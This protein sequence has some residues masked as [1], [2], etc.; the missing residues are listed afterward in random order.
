MTFSRKLEMVCF[1]I[2][3]AVAMA[4]S[5]SS[6]Q[7]AIAGTVFDSTGAVV[8]KANVTIHNSGNNTEVR[9]VTDSSGCF[10]APLLEPGTYIVTV[11]S[12]GFIDSRTNSVIGNTARIDVDRHRLCSQ[13][14]VCWSRSKYKLERMRRR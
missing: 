7:G 8:G 9:L 10:K 13:K 11:S 6:T 4:H 5:Q 1:L 14:M 2:L 3:I 12:P